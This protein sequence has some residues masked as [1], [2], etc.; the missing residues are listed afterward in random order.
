MAAKCVPRPL[1]RDLSQAIVV[2]GQRKKLKASSNV[3]VL[4]GK[5]Y[6]QKTRVP[7]NVGIVL[8]GI[9]VLLFF[10]KLFNC[11]LLIIS[12]S[13]NQRRSCKRVRFKMADTFFPIIAN[14]AVTFSISG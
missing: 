5:A 11:N 8:L 13:D 7:G 12:I 2:S 4:G 9:G 6:Y 1:K 14:M 3:R 10:G